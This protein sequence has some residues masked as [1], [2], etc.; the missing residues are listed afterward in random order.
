MTVELEK[1]GTGE[2]MHRG[3]VEILSKAFDG[4]CD[5][6]A[7]RGAASG[8]KSALWRYETCGR[9]GLAKTYDFAKRQ[10]HESSP[11]RLAC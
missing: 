2:G 1:S 10:A 4:L 7:P 5:F 3:C 8:A 6:C 9:Y 11:P